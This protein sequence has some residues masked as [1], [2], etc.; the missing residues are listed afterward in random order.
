MSSGNGLIITSLVF[1][2]TDPENPFVDHHYFDIEAFVNPIPLTR[3]LRGVFP[4]RTS[5]PDYKVIFTR[6]NQ[7][8]VY[9]PKDGMTFDP[10]EGL[11]V[12]MVDK[13]DGVFACTV[14]ITTSDGTKT[15]SRKW[16]TQ[17]TSKIFILQQNKWGFKLT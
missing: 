8:R 14:N 7:P 11:I 4:C 12:D 13:H 10:K 15:F 1:F 6:E 3:G 16:R 9:G 17:I 5:S 2:I